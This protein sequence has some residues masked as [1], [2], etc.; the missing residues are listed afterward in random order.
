MGHVWL[1]VH[2]IWWAALGPGPGPTVFEPAKD[3]ASARVKPET[4]GEPRAWAL[5]SQLV[6]R[7]YP[8][9][10]FFLAKNYSTSFIAIKIPSHV[11]LLG[12]LGLLPPGLYK[13]GQDSL[14]R[15]DINLNPKAQGATYYSP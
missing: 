10:S 2:L 5:C 13:G 9:D 12:L 11:I 3:E 4:M 1:V 14:D 7:S 8:D 6:R 15:K